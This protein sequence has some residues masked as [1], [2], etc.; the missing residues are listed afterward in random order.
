VI[1]PCDRRA[2]VQFEALQEPLAAID[3]LEELER[4]S[5][6]VLDPDR[7]TDSAGCPGRPALDAAASF[8]VPLL[9]RVEIRLGP[10]AKRQA[11]RCRLGAFAQH[12]AV[13]GR[14]FA[15]A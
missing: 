8:A 5:Q 4:E 3:R 6:R 2:V 7:F 14:L 12:E 1:D 10:H 11:H 15:A 13:M 9:G